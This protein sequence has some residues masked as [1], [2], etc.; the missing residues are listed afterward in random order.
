MSDGVSKTFLTCVLVGL[1]PTNDY[2]AG[3]GGSTGIANVLFVAHSDSL[4]PT[5]RVKLHI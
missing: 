3:T 1:L 2:E 4:S 5:R